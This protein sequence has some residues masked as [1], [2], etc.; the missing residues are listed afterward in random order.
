MEPSNYKLGAHGMINDA[1]RRGAKGLHPFLLRPGVT[2]PSLWYPDRPP[3]AEWDKIRSIVLERDNYA[4]SG[5]GHRALRYM[6]VHHLGESGDN[7]P[8]NLTTICVACHA[9]LHM[10]RNL[11]LKIIEIWESPF[12]QVEIVQRSR[13]GIRAG[14]SL[15]KIN[16][17][18]KLKPGPYPSTSIQYAEDLLQKIKRAPRAYLPE[19]LSAVFVALKR[20]QLE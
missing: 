2:N 11:D 7:R 17:G 5:C 9:I 12:S 3:K 1:L 8:E 18:F 19:P 16:K 14:L 15:E 6:N 4:C 13:E 10:G 20:W